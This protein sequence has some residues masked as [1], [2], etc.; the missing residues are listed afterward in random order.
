MK[1]KNL[2]RSNLSKSKAKGLCAMITM[3][4]LMSAPARADISTTISGG[5]GTANGTYTTFAA[6]IAA[7]NAATIAGPVTVTLTDGQ[8]ETLTSAIILTQSGTA[9][10]PI[11]FTK[12]GSGAKPILNGYTGT[13][14]TDAIFVLNGADYITIDGLALINNTGTIATTGMDYGFVLARA[15]AT[16]GCQNITIKN[17]LIRL[18]DS[19][20]TYGIGSVKFAY[21]EMTTEVTPTTSGGTNSAITVKSDSIYA[22]HGINFIA[23]PASSVSAPQTSG[24][25][26]SGNVIGG[27]LVS[28]GNYILFGSPTLTSAQNGI[29]EVWNYDITTQNNIVTTDEGA[30]NHS[31]AANACRGI[32]YNLSSPG[33]NGKIDNNTIYI[34]SNSTG[35]T[36][37]LSNTN[38]ITAIMC[39]MSNAYAAGGKVAITNNHISANVAASIP[40]S[41]SV[42]TPFCGIV[43]D[44]KADTVEISGNEISNYVV[45]ASEATLARNFF[46]IYPL[47]TGL[48][49][50][51]G[52]LKFKNNNIHDINFA[53]LSATSG[54]TSNF[55][56]IIG[57]YPYYTGAEVTGNTVANVTRT[58]GT[59]TVANAAF[60]AGSLTSSGS[61]LSLSY[62]TFLFKNNQVNNYSPGAGAAYGLHCSLSSTATPLVNIDS[63][64]FNNITTNTNGV[65]AVLNT[66]GISLA[67]TTL[68]ANSSISYNTITNITG[69]NTANA[70]GLTNGLYSLANGTYSIHHNTIS[71][72]TSGNTSLSYNTAGINLSAS[73]TSYS[74]DAYNNKITSITNT[75]TGNGVVYGISTGT[76]GALF[77]FYNNYISGLSAPNY[78]NTANNNVYSVT[79]FYL[80]STNSAT[81]YDVLNNT[82]M[83]GA[84]S[85]LSS[86]GSKF[87]VIG[88][89]YN[90]S[91]GNVNIQNNIINV[92]GISAGLG[93]FIAAVRCNAGTTL[94]TAGAA[95]G[96]LSHKNNILRTNSANNN[97]LYMQSSTAGTM[98]NAFSDS[99]FTSNTT[100]NIISDPSFNT[101]CGSFKAYM[102]GNANGTFTDNNMVLNGNGYYT[103]TGTSFA[104]SGAVQVS[105][106]NINTDL[107]NITRG[108]TPDMGAIEFN[109]TATDVSGPAITLSTLPSA[110]NCT[111]NFSFAATITDPSNVNINAGTK[112]RLYFKKTTDANDISSWKYTEGTN[113][114]GNSYTFTFDY[115]LLNTTITIADTIQYFIIAQDLSAGNYTGISTV[116]FNTCAL[117]VGLLTNNFPASNTNSFNFQP[118]TTVAV[119][120]DTS[121]VCA[122]A[123]KMFIG[124][125][126][127][128][129]NVT[130]GAGTSTT[131]ATNPVIYTA[132]TGKKT[133][134][135]FSA[136]ELTATGL[137]KGNI[138]ALTWELTIGSAALTNLNIKMGTTTAS[139]LTSTYLASPSTTVYDA[140]YNFVLGFNTVTFST[141]YF[142]DGVSNILIETCVGTSTSGATVT[143]RASSTTGNMANYRAIANACAQTTATAASAVRPFTSFNGN[144]STSYN[145]FTWNDGTANLGINN[146]TLTVTPSFPSGNTMNY[147]L[148]VNDAY[149]CAL[150]T[151]P[152]T[153]HKAT[154]PI[155]FANTNPSNPCAGAATLLDAGAAVVWSPIAGLY[156]DANATI[157]YTGTASQ[158]VY[159]LM[160]NNRF[161][162]ATATVSSCS[163]MDSVLVTVPSTTANAIASTTS[164]DSSYVANNSEVHNNACQLIASIS[165]NG[166]TPLSSVVKTIVTLDPSV[167]SVGG[168]PYLTR[169]YEI[170]PNTNGGTATA[171]VTLY[172]TQAEFNAYNTAVNANPAYPLFPTGP[173]D[174]AGIANIKLTKFEGT[175]ASPASNTGSTLVNGLTVAWDATLNAWKLSFNV[176]GFSSFYAHTNAT[177]TPLPVRFLNFTAAVQNNDNVLN[178][179]MAENTTG[180]FEVLHSLDGMNFETLGNV[181]SNNKDA[182]SFVQQQPSNVEFYKIAFI[183]PLGKTFYSSIQTVKRA[184]RSNMGIVLY[185]NPAKQN[186]I[187]VNIMNAAANCQYQIT[188][189]LG[190]EVKSGMIQISTNDS[191]T[192]VSINI[193]GLKDGIYNFKLTSGNIQL[194]KKLVKISK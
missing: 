48:V 62:T 23:A 137:S 134:L 109:G 135:I 114:S 52:Y 165:P 43:Y 76:T 24:L 105:N 143:M 106:P 124:N 81:Q 31:S 125:I 35:T 20:A 61:T 112:P 9:A 97:W 86:T 22:V 189:V 159:A 28:D 178:W 144:I 186:V 161:S 107:L 39:E 122:G 1:L 154:N 94:L 99:T 90:N 101:P 183:D 151:T 49:T 190:R 72:I 18:S 136:Q 46:G 26:D 100:S 127:R 126:T 129:G 95:P 187:N 40:A 41:S 167:Q 53:A 70:S 79:G 33:A 115:S 3:G 168:S 185:P 64:T 32:F 77:R 188:D 119:A 87:S 6:A 93:G 157:P 193:D 160:N 85:P 7:L 98:N 21:P 75:G 103:P 60:Q 4:V 108:A 155:V 194:S 111:S 163:F 156:S 117:S 120:Y 16:N 102:M 78:E 14:T 176:T 150:T 113:T 89:F 55:F 44:S 145:N 142:W 121:A 180:T 92:A 17:C 166:A 84:T 59:A 34:K 8:T 140:A 38:A 69:G 66:V 148:A 30:L 175:N 116:T 162:K 51:Q 147:T 152:A 96:N 192:N 123:S 47:G 57:L 139:A 54:T 29:Q 130:I 11:T 138:N 173:S 191:T 74:V 73:G 133:Q 13:T 104:E 25:R 82:V 63:N 177:N 83:L 164:T 71:N 146:D 36:T 179:T 181:K 153:I 169:H 10:S 67:A 88:V 184:G 131:Q 172:Y 65:T 174:A 12:S 110:M 27:P 132:S 68:L 91:T 80:G 58:A 5:G 182:Y 56:G 42:I 45:G 128:S 19:Y 158:T 50:A 171:N 2:L 118:V 170:T 15:S 149:G 37:T 141:P